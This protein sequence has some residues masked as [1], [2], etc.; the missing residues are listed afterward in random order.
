M[1]RMHIYIL[2]IKYFAIRIYVHIEELLLVNPFQPIYKEDNLRK[3]LISLTVAHR[4][5]FGYSYNRHALNMLA[6]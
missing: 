2:C 6:D 1:L 4:H 5:L 3:A